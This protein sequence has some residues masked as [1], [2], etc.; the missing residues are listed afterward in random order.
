[1]S[2]KRAKRHARIP[3]YCSCGKIV[4]GNGGK[5]AHKAMHVRAKDGHRWLTIEQFQQRIIHE[6]MRIY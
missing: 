3:H 2:S 5:A 4:H 1:M 6:G